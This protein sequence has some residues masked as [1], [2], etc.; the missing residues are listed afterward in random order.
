MKICHCV[1]MTKEENDA[2]YTA[3]GILAELRNDDMFSRGCEDEYGVSPSSIHYDLE[4]II[5]YLESLQ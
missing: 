3:L 1:K 5:A 2:L 4:N